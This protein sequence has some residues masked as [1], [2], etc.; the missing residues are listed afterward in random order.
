MKDTAN[1]SEKDKSAVL[2]LGLKRT[3]DD[4]PEIKKVTSLIHFII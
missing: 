2:G 3:K 1:Y 4:A